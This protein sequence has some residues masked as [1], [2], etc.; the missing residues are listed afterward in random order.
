MQVREE[1]PVKRRCWLLRRRKGAR[2]VVRRKGSSRPWRVCVCA[3]V[4]GS[5]RA[6]AGARASEQ[7]RMN[8]CVRVPAEMSVGPTAP[9]PPAGFRTCPGWPGHAKRTSTRDSTGPVLQMYQRGFVRG[10]EDSCNLH[11]ASGGTV[12]RKFAVPPPTSSASVPQRFSRSRYRSIPA[13]HKFRGPVP[14]AE[15]AREKERGAQQALQ[16]PR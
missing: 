14:A 4:W 9:L 13:P 1:P 16:V 8:V 12:R 5:E 15:A 6:G 7:E 3:F 2:E 11:R 10:N